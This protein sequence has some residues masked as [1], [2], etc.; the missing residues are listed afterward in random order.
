VGDVDVDNSGVEQ[1]LDD[2]NEEL[3]STEGDD[4]LASGENYDAV[5]ARSDMQGELGEG[6]IPDEE[7]LVDQS[8]FTDFINSNPY[9]SALENSGIQT[10][11]AYCSASVTTSLG[12]FDMDMCSLGPAFQDAG[13]ILLQIT[14]LLSLIIIVRG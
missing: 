12:S 1:R 2:V 9:K 3:S 10:S 6:E 11:G 14:A 7:S 4:A 5:G 8:W 13:V